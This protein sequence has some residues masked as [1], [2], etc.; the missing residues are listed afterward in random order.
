MT[1]KIISIKSPNSKSP[2]PLNPL[3][4]ETRLHLSN[5][6]KTAIQT[7]EITSII[8]YGGSNFSAGA[9]ITE[10]QPQNNNPSAKDAIAS[11]EGVPSLTDLAQQIESSNKPIVAALT[12]VVLGGGCELALACHFRVALKNCKIGLPEVKIGL[13]PGAGGTQRLPRLTKDV[14]WCLD[15]I[16]SGRMVGM[17][18]AKR[19]GVVD[20][21]VQGT[22][23]LNAAKKWARFGE[24]MGKDLVFR[25]S[26]NMRVFAEDDT[27]G[28]TRA[29][30]ICDQFLI[31]MPPKERGGESLHAAI[32]AVRT[33]FEQTDFEKS[34][35]IESD[36]FWDLL[37]NSKQ[38]RGL[39]YAF[40]AERA[41]A[42]GSSEY[43]NGPIA[44][45]L[46]RPQNDV[47]V[48]V[49]GAGTMG[50]GIAINFLR[51]GYKVI[52][53]D[54]NEKGLER[55]ASIISQIIQQDV[56]KKR[57]SVERAKSILSHNF[58][59]TVDMS[60]GDFCKC[61]LVVEAV[62]ENLDIK[63]AIFRQLD[64]VIL[65][66]QALLLSNTSTL[67]IN[68]IA[69]A[70]SPKR[71]AYCAGMHFFSPAHV[72][73]L[74]EIVVSSDTSPETIAL[75]QYIT[76]KKLKK[77][78][79]TV[80][81]CEG[82]VGNRMLFP[83]TGEATFVL[84]EGGATVS[85]VDNT[86][87]AF[88]MAIGPMNMGDLAGNDIG[89]L[90]RKGKGLTKDPKTGAPG[91]NRRRGM[92]YSDL[93]DDLV[94]K[95]G[96]VGQKAMKG[97]YDYDMKIG[98]GRKPIYS[99]EVEDFIVSY[100]DKKTKQKY[101]QTEIIERTLFPLVNEGFKILEENI[102]AKPSDIDVIYL[103]G[104]GWPAFRGGPMYWIDNEVGLGYFLNRLQDMNDKYPG[105]TYYIPSKL[106]KK[107]V[108]LGLTLQQYYEEG[109]QNTHKQRS[110]L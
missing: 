86:L 89:Y 11:S 100:G 85:E 70:L 41:I 59:T 68:S 73:K 60:Q 38:G 50:S 20:D 37:L 80:G 76:S 87:T 103:Y 84:E 32:A 90:V 43:L 67:N 25:K 62:F 61:I 34:M 49:V 8:L 105:S 99:K 24:L 82:F 21:V 33:S 92:R 15:V 95:L 6:L 110:K 1:V 83:Y 29:Q 26:S 2:N 101:S 102:A 46:N 35:N 39:R 56:K 14:L 55:G 36:L 94:V 66:P 42:K 13:I 19:K 109:M 78:G 52:L 44:Q 107:C 53:V 51:A 47:Y 79:V 93:P 5:A 65:N 63:Q 88:G 91:P 27:L 75:I 45:A 104:Y 108:A 97:W 10:F 16:T 54:N 106:L 22:D 98:K 9:D 4:R 71:R 17:D 74:V 57:I 48:G 7:P 23:I 12:G 18:E 81:N 30:N 77:V 64:Q 40:F 28:I 31:K 3:S 96:R 72:M 69:S 58:F